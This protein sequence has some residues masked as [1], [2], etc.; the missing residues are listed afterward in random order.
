MDWNWGLVSIV[1]ILEFIVVVI[2][3]E[4]ILFTFVNYYYPMSETNEMD[5]G[6]ISPTSL[7]LMS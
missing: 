4:F 6:T 5:G 2:I 7:C 1:I 3:L